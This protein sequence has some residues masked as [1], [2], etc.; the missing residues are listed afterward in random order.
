MPHSIAEKF[1]EYAALC[2]RFA[3]A[4]PDQKLRAHFLAQA[5]GWERDASWVRRDRDAIEASRALLAKLDADGGGE[6]G[7]DRRPE[8]I[9]ASA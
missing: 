5:E 4:V 2:R 6:R 8:S 1:L 7:V 9:S 3:T